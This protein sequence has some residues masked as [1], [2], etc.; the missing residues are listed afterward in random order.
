MAPTTKKLF[1]GLRSWADA[2]AADEVNCN[3]PPN[4]QF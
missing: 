3:M 2:G 4:A 1:M